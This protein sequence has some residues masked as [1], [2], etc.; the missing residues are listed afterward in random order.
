MSINHPE[1]SLNDCNP[2]P[3]NIFPSNTDPPAGYCDA[4]NDPSKRKVGSGDWVEDISSKK[5]GIGAQNLCD[6]MQTGQIV[7]DI[8]NPDRNTIY[9]YSKA[10]RGHDEAMLDIFKNIVVIDEDGKAHPVPIIY[11]SQERAVAMILQD[12]VRKDES[13]VVDRIKLPMMA[14]VQSG[15]NFNQQRYTYHRAKDF[16]RDNQGRPSLTFNEKYEKDTVFGVTRGLPV[17]INYTLS[18]WTAYIEDINQIFEQIILKFSPVAYIKVRGVHWEIQVK[19]DT[20]ANTIDTEPGDQ[21]SRIV[22]YEY[23][24]TVESYIP[25]PMYRYKSVLSTKIDLFND[26]DENVINANYDRL[27]NSVKEIA[28]D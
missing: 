17:D 22:K 24:F 14:I 16:L 20:I 11:G 12:N 9:R 19:L 3:P 6:P 13:L 26:V 1:K 15:I 27:E 5:V 25:Q 8:N 23:S 7:N 28:N 2:K 10:L 21:K 18:V 4:N